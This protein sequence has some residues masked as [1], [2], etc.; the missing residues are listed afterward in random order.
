PLQAAS[1]GSLRSKSEPSSD[2]DHGFLSRDQSN[3]WKGWMQGLL[4]LYHYHYASQS[5][6]VYKIVR[7]LVSSYI[8]LS[9]YGH[10]TYLL[11]TNDFSL[12]RVA[13]TVFRLNIFSAL[14]PYVMMT[15]YDFYY[16]AP[17]VTFWFLAVWL[18]LR[19]FST[20]NQ[21]PLIMLLKV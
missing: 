3:E 20:F 6:W 11:R 15:E 9:A 19:L 10:T 2:S 1:P 14:L 4:L 16:F 18:T 5:L 17:V 7:L 12:R 8:F 21:D 13:F